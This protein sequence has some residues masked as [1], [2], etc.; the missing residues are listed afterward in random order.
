MGRSY[1]HAVEL[2]LAVYRE[3][4]VGGQLHV[5]LEGEVHD[6]ML[7]F[8]QHDR[9]TRTEGRCLA[10]LLGLSETER[11]LALAAAE[12]EMGRGHE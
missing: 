5:V 7:R 11:R 2:I 4:P 9:L 12:V 1:T 10:V 3:H 6:A 8:H